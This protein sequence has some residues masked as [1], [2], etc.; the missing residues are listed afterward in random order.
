[1]IVIL[2]E[3]GVAFSLDQFNRLSRETLSVMS[4]EGRQICTFADEADR[5]LVRHADGYYADEWGFRY[6]AL[7]YVELDAQGREIA[8]SPANRVIPV[9]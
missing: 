7:Y 9:K 2:S 3:H 5:L 6:D 8:R 4:D 1:M